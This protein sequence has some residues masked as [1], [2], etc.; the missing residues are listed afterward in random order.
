MSRESPAKSRSRLVKSMIEKDVD[1]S[2]SAILGVY[3]DETKDERN[4]S[5]SPIIAR[6]IEKKEEG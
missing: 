2:K 5:K 6:K 4:N 3:G 1:V